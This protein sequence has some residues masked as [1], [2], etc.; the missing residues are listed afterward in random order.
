MRENINEMDI[1]PGRI[2]LVFCEDKDISL[3]LN[4]QGRVQG[5]TKEVRRV[6]R[7]RRLA[8]DEAQAQREG[9]PYLAGVHY[10]VHQVLT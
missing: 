5:T 2:M 6:K 1:L 4:A 3:I 10:H 9:W 7:Q 8:A